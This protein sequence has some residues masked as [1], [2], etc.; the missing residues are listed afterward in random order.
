MISISD[1]FTK[2]INSNHVTIYPLVILGD[3]IFADHPSGGV[4][5]ALRIST[6]KETI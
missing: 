2:D 6:V 4:E 3:T 5:R 1:L